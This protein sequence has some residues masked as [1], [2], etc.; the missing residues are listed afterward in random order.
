[1][2]HITYTD[3]AGRKATVK[4]RAEQ[5]STVLFFIKCLR[6]TG[7]EYEHIFWD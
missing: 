3:Y 2:H 7:I 5:I 1:M 4:L 6:N